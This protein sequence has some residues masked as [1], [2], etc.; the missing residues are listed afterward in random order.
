MSKKKST[1][2]PILET[3][4]VST[5]LRK[6]EPPLINLQVSNPVTYLKSWWKRVL[7]GEGVDFRFKIQPLTAI[8]MTIVIAT[9]GFGAGRISLST[10][11]PYIQLITNAATTTQPSP[12]PVVQ[13]LWRETAFSGMLKHSFF[14]NRYYLITNNSEAITLEVP[15]NVEL[16]NLIGRRIFATGK[17]NDKTRVLVVSNASDLEVLPETVEEVPVVNV[18]EDQSETNETSEVDVQ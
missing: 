10:T 7:G 5:D 13:D 16:K 9:I 3:E 17:Y 12:A 6:K 8:G 18:D 14:D 15:E 1:T 4:V 2:I 11:K